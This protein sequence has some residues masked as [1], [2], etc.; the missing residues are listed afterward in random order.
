[1]AWETLWHEPEGSVEQGKTTSQA[2]SDSSCAFTGPEFD[3]SPHA[4]TSAAREELG[5]RLLDEQAGP[6]ARRGEGLVGVPCPQ[7]APRSEAA[8]RQ[9]DCP[10]PLAGQV[11]REWKRRL[12]P[13]RS[14]GLA[15]EHKR[16][17][18]GFAEL[19]DN[20]G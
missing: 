13:L 4:Q 6:S 20:S 2:S 19:S 16:R 15:M 9:V 17:G 14:A 11:G 7:A 12:T 8:G 18:G 5:T 1:M 10:A 3:P